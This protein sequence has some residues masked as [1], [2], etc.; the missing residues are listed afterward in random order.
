MRKCDGLNMDVRENKQG[1]CGI[2]S[3]LARSVSEEHARRSSFTHYS[4]ELLE[5]RL[6]ERAEIGL[7][8]PSA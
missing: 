2:F 4:D 1:D 6:R 5:A 3:D 7:I 8:A